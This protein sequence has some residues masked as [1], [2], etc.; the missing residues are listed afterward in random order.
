MRIPTLASNVTRA[1][2]GA[3]L[4][5]ALPLLPAGCS[6]GPRGTSPTSP[7][8]Q[9]E[10]AE[11][12]SGLDAGDPR[13]PLGEAGPRAPLDASAGRPLP[14]P[15]Y[16]GANVD[17][18][19]VTFRVWAPNAKA[20]F[21]RGDFTKADLPMR[22]V[23]GGVFEAHAEGAHAGSR[24]RFILDGANGPL[25]R[26]DPY[27]RELV[28]EGCAVV[29]PREYRWTDGAHVPT[30]RAEAIVYELHVGSFTGA[31]GAR[32]GTFASTREALPAL[33][34]LGVT[35]LE[36]LPVQAYGGGPNGWGYNPQHFHAPM[37]SLGSLDDFRALVDGAHA[38]G[39]SVWI[40]TVVNHTDGW[41]QAPLRCFDGECPNGSAGI[42][43]FGPGPYASTP[44]G[45]RP[46]YA[47]PEV[48]T[49]LA[50][51]I[52][53][54][55][56]ELH[57]DGFRVDSVSNVRAVDGKGTVPGGRELLLRMNER[58][59]A[60]GGLSVAEDLKGYAAIT[61][62]P[63]KGG[64]G[65]D[66]QW[67][68]FGYDLTSVLTPPSDAGR[69][70][71]RV[72][73]VLRGAPGSDPFARLLFLENHDTVGNG[74]ARLPARID[75]ANPTSYAARKRSM[76]AGVLL[77]TAPGVPMLFMG[78]DSLAT[79]PF[80]SDPAPLAEATAEGKRVRAFFRDMIRLRRNLDGRAGG[81]SGPTVEI[82][83]RNDTAKVLAY[84]RTGASGEEVLVIVNLANKAYPEYLVGVDDGRPWSVRLDT[85]LPT[86][87]SDFGGKP[88]GTLAPVARA[89]DGKAH[90]LPLVLGAYSAVVL[91]R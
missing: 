54:W 34:D 18:T 30:P 82:T 70:L 7:A 80:T 44:W 29:D 56:G 69:D 76:L 32:H 83:H 11:P 14:S 74:G 77:L 48:A 51:S 37:P 61:G 1:W 78:Q 64:F 90:A 13:S 9:D 36:L 2:V 19:G 79:A 23:A 91:T 53:T 59:H 81:L 41:S 42:Y 62:D 33:A 86:Y 72:V 50:T 67:D 21:V 40:D 35:V 66:A 84:R 31:G 60:L 4:V 27:C 45:P 88:Q 43:F 73:D 47:T 57:A 12:T 65:F 15:P 75:G 22:S 58:I 71:G 16:L 10:A 6:G 52:D 46:S 17:A 39:M 5:A 8:L 85:D 89:V 38:L 3:G 49:F 26:I 55:M 24:Y 87:G 68:G 63:S 28:A 20:A 25:T